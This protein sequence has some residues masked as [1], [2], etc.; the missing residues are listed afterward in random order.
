MDEKDLIKQLKLLKSI[1]PHKEWVVS[2]K[3]G[4]FVNEPSGRAL[5][6][7]GFITNVFS[8]FEQHAVSF[9]IVAFVALVVVGGLFYFTTQEADVAYKT[10][11]GLLAKVASQSQSSEA[12]L[13]SLSELQEKLADVTMAVDKLKNAKDQ[14]QALVMTE[15]VKTTAKEGTEVMKQLKKADGG[16]SKQALASLVEVEEL[17]EELGEK[18]NNLQKEIFQNYLTDLKQ[19]SLSPEDQERLEKAEEL[20]SQGKEGE[21]MILLSRIGQ[22]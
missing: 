19:R 14:G 10:L 21:A 4:L 18:S 7:P 2:T 15:V 5:K 9:S 17:S 3:K 13:T 8:L 16:L 22:K 1:K 12:M 20:Y 6:T 11:E